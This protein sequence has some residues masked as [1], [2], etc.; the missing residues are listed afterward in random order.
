MEK[1]T[2]IVDL[3]CQEHLEVKEKCAILFEL[4]TFLDKEGTWEKICESLDFLDRTLPRHC[5]AEA[6]LISRLHQNKAELTPDEKQVLFEILEEHKAM[7]AGLR[8][9]C[10]VAEEYEEGNRNICEVL[11]TLTRDAIDRIFAHAG[12][13]D[14]LLFEL[15]RKYIDSEQ[16]RDY[17]RMLRDTK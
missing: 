12:K 14:V 15:I 6:T 13:E 11:V 5:E 1:A 2:D 10:E 16:L 3:L 4:L 8:R 17:K 7:L 9:L